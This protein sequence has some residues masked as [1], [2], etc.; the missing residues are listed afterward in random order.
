[1]VGSGDHLD[2]VLKDARSSGE[3]GLRVIEG[4]DLP[5]VVDPE[6]QMVDDMAHVVE[7]GVERLELVDELALH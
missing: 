2:E 3:D 6:G 5:R 4:V 1:M 7:V